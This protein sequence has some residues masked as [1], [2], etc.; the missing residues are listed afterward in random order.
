MSIKYCYA[1][2]FFMNR[3]TL[4]QLKIIGK[5]CEDGHA[6]AGDEYFGDGCNWKCKWETPLTDWTC[7][8]SG[9]LGACVEKCAATTNDYYTYGCKDSNLVNGDGCDS[10]CNIEHG[11]ECH[12]G[13]PMDYDTC[14]EVCGDGMLLGL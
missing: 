5:E 9:V 8:A 13:S 1:F 11:F 2:I 6:N 4:N 14:T 10:T 12:F 7:P 3:I